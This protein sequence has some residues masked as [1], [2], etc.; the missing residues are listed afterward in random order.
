VIEVKSNLSTQWAQ[1]RQTTQ[2]AKSLIKHIRDLDENGRCEVTRIPVYAVGFRGWAN[3][4]SLKQHWE[5]TANDDRPDAVLMI[6]NAAFVSA[7]IQAEAGA[8]LV[9]FIAHLDQTIR[10]HTAIQTNLF[11]YMGPPTLMSESSSN[12]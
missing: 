3:L 9:A 10:R 11:R 5:E 8:A 2:Q 12:D 1:V 4:S 6:E 7:D